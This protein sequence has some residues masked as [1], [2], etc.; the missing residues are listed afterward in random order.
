MSSRAYNR[1][2]SYRKA[3][4]KQR[5]DHELSY[6]NYMLYDNLHQYSKNKIH[7]SCGMCMAKTR[8]KSPHRRHIHA[9]YAPAI[10]YSIRDRRALDKLNYVEEERQENISMSYEEFKKYMTHLKEEYDFEITLLHAGISIDVPQINNI[11]T[12]ELELLKR[13]FYDEEDCWIEYFIY[14]IEYGTKC[15]PGVITDEHGSIKLK[16]PADLYAMLTGKPVYY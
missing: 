2:V 3:K 15:A 1:D 9:N 7:C 6:G 8:N 10:N 12:D 5:L 13:F 4:R 16:T 14:E 11:L